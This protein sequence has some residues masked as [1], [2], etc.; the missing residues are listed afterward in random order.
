LRR[1]ELWKLGG[2]IVS[3]ATFETHLALVDEAADAVAVGPVRGDHVTVRTMRA[4]SSAVRLGVLAFVIAG[5]SGSDGG[6]RDSDDLA[7]SGGRPGGVSGGV[8]GG[9]VSGGG[10]SGGGVSGGGVSGGGAGGTGTGGTGTGGTAGDGGAG[11]AGLAGRGLGGAG[12]GGRGGAGGAGG[13]N[14]GGGGAGGGGAGGGGAGGGGGGAG[15]TESVHYYGRWNRLAD[16]AITVNT[17]SHVV[18]RFSGTGVSARFNVSLNQTP[19]P[20]LAWRVDQA[21]WQEGELSATLPLATGLAAGAHEVTLMVRGLNENQNRWRAP[22]V[23]SITF[24]GFDIAGTGGAV[25]PSP[26]P[27]RPKIEF[28]GDSITEGVN[29]WTSR[30]GQTTPC[31]RSD[32]RIA[33]ASQTAQA[34]GVEWRQ[35]GFG[36][37]GLLIGGNGGVPVAND[38]FN[39]IYDGVRRDDWQADMV[40]VNQGTNDGGATAANFGPAYSTFLATIRAAYSAAKIVAMRP[41]GGAHASEIRSAV[42]ARNLA[43]D[44]RVYYIDTTGWLGTGDF[45]DGLHPNE[46]GSGKAAT[47]LTAALRSIGL[48]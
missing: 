39:S 35:V 47:Q 46:Q 22:L 11:N 14:A 45:T 2:P 42:D 37:Q 44:S 25:Q 41:F 40:V 5:C 48:P 20:T 17:G 13:G 19:N 4:L 3:A 33:Y 21:P 1:D 18:A 38:A 12:G 26:R 8:S 30:N 31:W 16:R 10:V 15:V 23:S 43:G 24:L 29:L 34:L 28:L 32:G 36:R 6:P 7:G 9:G 27:V